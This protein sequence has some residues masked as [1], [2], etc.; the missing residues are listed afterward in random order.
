ME[1]IFIRRSVRKYKEQKI[2]KEKIDKLLRA[3]F[4][5][6]WSISVLKGFE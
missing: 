5:N 2:E 1:S 6:L 3:V 4:I